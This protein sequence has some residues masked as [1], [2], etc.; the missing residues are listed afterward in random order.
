MIHRTGSPTASAG[1]DL[2]ST[3]PAPG[4]RSTGFLAQVV[5]QWAPLFA[6]DTPLDACQLD[7][8]APV[9]G[10]VPVDLLGQLIYEPLYLGFLRP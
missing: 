2:A 1:E 5:L 9:E 6:P 4:R 10:L 7:G 8:Q 3:R